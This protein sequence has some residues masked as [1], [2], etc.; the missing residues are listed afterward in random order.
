MIS[1]RNKMR[2]RYLKRDPMVVKRKGVG[3]C[4]MTV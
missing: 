4:V 2:I 3:F 1:E